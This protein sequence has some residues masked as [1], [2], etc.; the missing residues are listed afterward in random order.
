MRLD[1]WLFKFHLKKGT[2]VKS[3]DNMV[4]VIYQYVDSDLWYKK[5]TAAFNK[6]LE[7]DLSDIYD[8]KIKNHY[9]SLNNKHHLTKW[10]QTCEGLWKIHVNKAEKQIYIEFARQTDAAMFRIMAA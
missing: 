8:Q 1:D 3:P 9:C 6:I 5:Y 7:E 4:E 10:L 2:C